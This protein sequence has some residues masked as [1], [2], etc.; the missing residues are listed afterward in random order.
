MKKVYLIT[1]GF[2]HLGYNLVSML[3]KTGDEITAGTVIG[4]AGKSAVV[5]QY[6]NKYLLHFAMLEN[7]AY[8]DPAEYISQ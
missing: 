8:K 2:G 6:D 3:L 7:G 5:E 1:G 4:K